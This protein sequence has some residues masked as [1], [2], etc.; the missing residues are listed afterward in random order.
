MHK[1]K[2]GVRRRSIRCKEEVYDV[3][4]YTRKEVCPKKEP[5][6]E[7]YK[8]IRKEE[9]YRK[10]YAQVY[11]RKKKYKEEAYKSIR[12]RALYARDA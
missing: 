7:V 10:K 2:G 9:V 5:K 11:I 4:K 12:A 6:E 1:S 3:K 8:S